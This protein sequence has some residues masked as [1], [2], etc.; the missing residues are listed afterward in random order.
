MRLI[1]NTL[2]GH[3]VILF[4]FCLSATDSIAIFASYCRSPL[5]FELDKKMFSAA[6]ISERDSSTE[7]RGSWYKEVAEGVS[8]TGKPSSDRTEANTQIAVFCTA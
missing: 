2:F 7:C 4:R 8:T 5:T 1:F 6:T 3:K